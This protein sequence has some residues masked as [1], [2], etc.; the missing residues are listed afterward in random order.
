MDS[1]NIP[2]EIFHISLGA[3]SCV[4][5][6]DGPSG[7][8]EYFTRDVSLVHYRAI[9]HSAA[10]R[11][12]LPINNC[13]LSLDA[14]RLMTIYSCLSMVM[15]FY[16]EVVCIC[17]SIFYNIYLPGH[18]LQTSLWPGG[19]QPTIRWSL[20]SRRMESPAAPLWFSKNLPIL[21]FSN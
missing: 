1:R 10:P 2:H 21:C 17:R 11:V 18:I 3:T 8:V 15:V 5:Q 9:L 16:F 14:T 20:P 6:E 19:S 12:I 4:P 13:K 7:Y